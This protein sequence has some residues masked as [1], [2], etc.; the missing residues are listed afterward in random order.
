MTEKLQGSISRGLAL[1]E[2]WPVQITSASPRNISNTEF[3]RVR[4]AERSKRRTYITDPVY[5]DVKSYSYA[6]QKT[7]QKEAAR[8]G[9]RIKNLLSACPLRTGAAVHLLLNKGLLSPYELI[10]IESLLGSNSEKESYDRRYHRD[11][12]LATQ[13]EMKE[14]NENTVDAVMLAA[15]ASASS[16]KLIEKAR[17]RANLAL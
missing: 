17:L 13:K 3:K 4:F 15:V 11:L 1:I 6:D 2:E 14:K 12:V 8:E 10:G 7:F 16:S 9:L 5:E